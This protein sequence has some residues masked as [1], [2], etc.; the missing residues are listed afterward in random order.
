[1]G[2]GNED[3][4]YFFS[5]GYLNDDGYAI[6]TGYD[7]YTTRLNLD[8]NV[9]EWLKVGANIGYAYSESLNNGQTVGSENVFEFADKTAPI[10]PVF[11][12]DNNDQLIEDPIFGGYINMILVISLVYV[13]VISQMV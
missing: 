1:M 2:G 13:L 3:T 12:R 10:F 11:L 5:L 4:K 6:N 8:S 7:R 9:K